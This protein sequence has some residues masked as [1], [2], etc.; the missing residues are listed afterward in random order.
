[1]KI[2]TNKTHDSYTC[3]IQIHSLNFIFNLNAW[4]LLCEICHIQT[5]S[6]SINV[7]PLAKIVGFLY[8]KN[9]LFASGTLR[10][11]YSCVTLYETQRMC[12]FFR[13][14][15]NFIFSCNDIQR[16][17]ERMRKECMFYHHILWLPGLEWSKNM[18]TSISSRLKEKMIISLIST[19]AMITCL[20]ILFIKISTSHN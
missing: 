7:F 4:N 18:P 8:Q 14:Q 5:G 12:G 6:I 9:T 19:R 3:W 15:Y 1:M 13:F 11:R 16:C 2:C 17:N 10:K 20:T